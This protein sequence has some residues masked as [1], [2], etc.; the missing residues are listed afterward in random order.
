MDEIEFVD[1][2][3]EDNVP[4][5]GVNVDEEMDISSEEDDNADDSGT[6]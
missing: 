3:E 6:S 4:E 2:V 1:E 5:H